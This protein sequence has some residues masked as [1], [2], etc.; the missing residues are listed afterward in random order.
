M[1]T[2]IGEFISEYQNYWDCRLD[3]WFEQDWW[4]CFGVYKK[5]EGYD[6]QYEH[7]ECD[8]CDHV[9]DREG[10]WSQAQ[11]VRCSALSREDFVMGNLKANRPI[12]NL[13]SGTPDSYC[14]YVVEDD[15]EEKELRIVSDRKVNIAKI[16]TGDGR[17]GIRFA[18]DETD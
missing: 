7:P 15:R 10:V 14:G 3:T 1:E 17:V 13:F 12:A 6:M 8:D 2:N 16:L 4:V 5:D 18:S 11:K 9:I